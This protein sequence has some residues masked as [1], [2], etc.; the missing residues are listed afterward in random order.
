MFGLF[1]W[2]RRRR[3]KRRPFPPEWLETLR[4]RV[5]F[6]RRLPASLAPLFREQ[7]KLFVWEKEFIGAGGMTLTDEV[8]VVIGACA[9]RLT[10]NLDVSFYDRLTE[11]VVYP[12][13][14]RA[15]DEDG[16]RLGEAHQWGVVVLSWAAV[17][18]GLRDSD[19]GQATGAHE[20][21]HV[22]DIADGSFDGTPKL[23]ALGD[24]KQWATVMTENFTRLRAGADQQE[25]VIDEYGAVDEAE[26]FAVATE[27]FFERPGEMGRLLPDLHQEL[28]RFYGWDPGAERD[29]PDR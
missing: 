9:V 24:Y 18:D 2:L 23:R 4:R 25:R 11:I 29:D 14:F 20:F 26:F 7:L 21:A 28:Q 27:A 6:Y 13:A 15:P 5:P 22:L 19:D 12:G 3:L 1:R 17:L 8:R 16:G 10:L